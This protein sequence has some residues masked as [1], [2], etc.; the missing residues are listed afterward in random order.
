MKPFSHALILVVPWG[1]CL[2]LFVTRGD[3]QGQPKAGSVANE[4]Q[5][6]ERLLKIAE[7]YPVYGRVDDD[8]RWSPVFCRRPVP[9]KAYYSRSD[10]KTTHGQKLYSLFARDRAAYVSMKAPGE[11]GQV[12]V[13]ESWMPVEVKGKPD[14]ER[15]PVRNAVVRKLPKPPRD[16]APIGQFPALS[17]RDTFLP[18]AEKAGKWYKADHRGDLFIMMRL[19]PKTAGTDDGW[20]Y[21][22]VSADGKR[23]TS[24]GR[25]ASCMECHKTR[26]TRLFGLKPSQE[27]KPTV[28]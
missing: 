27:K 4:K 14:T 11:V 9:A 22:T 12:V 8:A 20:V 26:P 21:G 19:D 28:P 5:F 24:A 23:V 16:L 10:D 25:V 3:T 17:G 1:L 2:V 15:L 18:F 7:I 13:K 6:Q